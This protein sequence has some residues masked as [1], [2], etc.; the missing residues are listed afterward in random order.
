LNSALAEAYSAAARTAGLSVES[1]DIDAL[2][3]D[4]RLQGGY[5]RPQALEPALGELQ[6]KIAQA[7]HLVVASPVWWGSVPA[8]FKGFIDRVFLPGWAFRSGGS[9]FPQR[10]LAGRSAR[11]LLTMDA[12]GWWDLFKYGRSASRQLEKAWLEFVGIKSYGV[13]RF[14]SIEKTDAQARHKM[15]EHAARLGRRDAHK[16]LARGLEKATSSLAPTPV[17]RERAA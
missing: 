8:S 3:F 14:T 16:V 5:S 4:L 2:D 11:V 13:E 1:V 10:G 6:A 12:P 17:G 7:A 9:A 15:L